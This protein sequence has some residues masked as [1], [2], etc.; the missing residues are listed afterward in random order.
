MNWYKTAFE[1]ETLTDRNR[2]NE[3]IYEFEDAVRI[4][5]YM[6]DYVFQNA[7]HAKKII[8]SIANNKRLS[9]F[10]LLKDTL[11]YAASKALDNYKECSV[12]CDEVAIS[13][14]REVEKMKKQR[15]DFSNNIYPKQVKERWNVGQEKSDSKKGK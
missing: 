6:V 9:S 11:V 4:L 14:F 8:L 12:L 10:P 3:R 1:L 5:K 7:A 13:L 15:K 2:L